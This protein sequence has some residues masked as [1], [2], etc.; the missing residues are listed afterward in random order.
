V[1]GNVRPK[2][3]T[4]M[5]F[6]GYLLYSPDYKAKWFEFISSRFVIQTNKMQFRADL[7]QIL[8]TVQFTLI[9]CPCYVK[10]TGFDRI[11]VDSST[12]RSYR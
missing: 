9:V 5:L 12:D 11:Y 1:E 6:K 2:W 4:V 7:L 8:H 3:T 10:N